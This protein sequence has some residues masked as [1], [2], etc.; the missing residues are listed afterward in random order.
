MTFPRRECQPV[1]VSSQA[2]TSIFQ[3]EKR[4]SFARK[5]LATIVL[6]LAGIAFSVFA[7][8][9][10]VH[11][12]I[13]AVVRW[14]ALVPLAF[15]CIFVASALMFLWVPKFPRRLYLAIERGFFV[16]VVLGLPAL[17]AVL[18]WQ[19]LAGR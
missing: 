11:P 12:G 4:V 3:F 5:L 14:G 6:L 16:L 9:V 15:C 13:V 19:T 1:P 8:V 2:V 17:T 7:L 18:L 10:R